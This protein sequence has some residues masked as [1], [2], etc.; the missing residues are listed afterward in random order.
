[1]SSIAR[2]S[3]YPFSSKGHASTSDRAKALPPWSVDRARSLAKQNNLELTNAHLYVLFFLRDFYVDRGW[4]K[5]THAL[6]QALDEEF[7]EKGGKKYLH[8][9]FPH[10]PV[11]QGTRIA[12]LPVP[13]YAEDKSFGSVQ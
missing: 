2:N 11:A 13:A 7:K 5:N 1:M 12:G 10:G 8:R 9:L 3:N 4:P 6:A